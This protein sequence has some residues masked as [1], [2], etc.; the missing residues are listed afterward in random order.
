LPGSER[1]GGLTRRE[2]LVSGTLAA[3]YALAVRPVRAEAI[4][5]DA[6][7]LVTGLVEIPA[8]DRRI[9]AYRARP[10]GA[11][12]FPVVLVVHEI[13]GVH[14]YIRDVCRRLARAGYLAVAPDLYLRQGDPTRLASIDAIV[15]EIVAR[16]PDAQVMSDLDAA[17]AWAQTDGGVVQV[18]RSAPQG[19]EAAAQRAEGERSAGA[20]SDRPRGEAQPSEAPR[21]GLF[22]TGFCW[23]GRIV[24]LYAAHRRD[25][26]AG[27]AWYGRLTGPVRPETPE[28]PIDLA[29]RPL[30]PVLGL[31]GAEDAGIPLESVFAMRKQ[32][33][34]AGSAS[35]IVVFP[36]APHGFHADYR[37]SYRPMAAEEGWRRMLEWFRRHAD[38]PA[39]A[40]G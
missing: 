7:S 11:G 19:R 2:L 23:G 5:T 24:W 10:E 33:A 14:E 34:Q 18:S 8:A 25:L 36:E 12:P 20:R 26:E 17:A 27:A 39:R 16:V 40:S 37:E 22:A 1:P 21:A 3:G 6:S 30:A 32:L 38:R 28:H 9:A 29:E 35:E 4:R 15:G 31:Y 13:F